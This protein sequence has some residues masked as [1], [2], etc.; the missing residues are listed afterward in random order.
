MRDYCD[1]EDG[2]VKIQG[3]IVNLR[4]NKGVLNIVANFEIAT[5]VS[6]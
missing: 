1:S 2:L 4:Y 3:A 6:D 5:T